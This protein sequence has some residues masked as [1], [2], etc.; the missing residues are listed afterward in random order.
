MKTQTIQLAAKE[1]QVIGE[2][3]KAAASGPFF[4]D[5]EFH[6]LLGLGREELSLLAS[7]WTEITM[8]DS[9]V[10]LA[11][12]NALTN[13]L[14]YPHGEM[15]TWSKFISIT[16]EALRALFSK[17]RNDWNESGAASQ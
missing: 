15:A 17:C 13:L 7:R 10:V 1:R 6:A 3:L 12:N 11:V 14:G 5:E 2:C 8:W 16:P 4:P 9:Q